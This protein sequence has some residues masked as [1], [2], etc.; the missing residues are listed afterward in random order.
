M[1][2]EEGIKHFCCITTTMLMCLQIGL[3]IGLVRIEPRRIGQQI[4]LIL[5]RSQQGRTGGKHHFY[6]HR[7]V[8]NAHV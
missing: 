7:P 1:H 3:C 4:Q 2:W 6:S 5:G 8:L